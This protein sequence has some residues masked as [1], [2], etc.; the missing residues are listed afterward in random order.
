MD[1][2]DTL[3]TALE[4]DPR[5]GLTIISANELAAAYF[6]PLN[7]DL[8]ALIIDLS[9][10]HTTERVLS[11]LRSLYPHDHRVALVRDKADP[12]LELSLDELEAEPKALAFYLPP[13]EPHSSYQARASW[14]SIHKV[15]RSDAINISSIELASARR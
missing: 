9:S 4:L 15:N 14:A 5:Q 2:I 12:V 1:A 11:V 3:L 7:P 10:S 13:L 6:P 8:G